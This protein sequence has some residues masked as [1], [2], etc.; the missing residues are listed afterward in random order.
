GAKPV[1]DNLLRQ[2]RGDIPRA[3]HTQHDAWNELHTI[4]HAFADAV[5]KELA[6]ARPGDQTERQGDYPKQAVDEEDHAASS[7]R[8]AISD[9]HRARIPAT[10]GSG[11]AMIMRQNTKCPPKNGSSHTSTRA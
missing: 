7:L 11:M 5:A 6:A 1:T 2:D 10:I 9:I 3:D 8:M 4:D